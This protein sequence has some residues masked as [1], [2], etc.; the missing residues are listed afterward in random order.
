MPPGLEPR[1][2][3]RSLVASGCASSSMIRA[4]WLP[5]YLRRWSVAAALLVAAEAWAEHS[6]ASVGLAAALAVA[7]VLV[8]V[9][10]LVTTVCWTALRTP[11]RS[12]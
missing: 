2:S 9:F 4:R 6:L 3:A 8:L 1:R 7:L 10:I 12:R 5:I 11:P